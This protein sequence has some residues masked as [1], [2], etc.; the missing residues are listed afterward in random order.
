MER[1]SAEW[2]ETRK[3]GKITRKTE[4]DTIQKLVE[5]EKEQGCEHAEMLYMTYSKLANRTVG[6]SKRDEAT[7]RHL[8]KLS[9]MEDAIFKIIDAGILQKKHYK[10]IYAD[11]KQNLSIIK[12][13]AGGA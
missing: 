1:H 3:Y 4:T 13:M 12:Q 6:I 7:T 9:F 11:C 8:Y 5:Y 2:V 10:Q